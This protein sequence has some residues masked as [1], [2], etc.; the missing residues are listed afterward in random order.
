LGRVGGV[1]PGSIGAKGK[2]AIAVAPSDSGLGDED[3]LA[4]IN[5]RDRQGA[6][7]GQRGGSVFGDSPSAD[8]ADDSGVVD[9]VDGDGDDTGGAICGDGGEAV[10][11]RV[12]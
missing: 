9:A 4:G 8:P 10:G 7:G 6:G 2:G 1:G 11:E 3:G 5:I 12:I